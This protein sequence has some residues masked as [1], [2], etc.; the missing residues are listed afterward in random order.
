MLPKTASLASNSIAPFTPP[1][2]HPSV[3][4]NTNYSEPRPSMY[5]TKQIYL[6]YLTIFLY[7]SAHDPPSAVDNAS[8]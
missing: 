6:S 4:T 3:P 7:Y 2:S 1:V 5:E 8:Q